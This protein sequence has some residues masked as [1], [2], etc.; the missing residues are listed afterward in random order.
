MNIGAEAVAE[1][2]NGYAARMY[3]KTA[4]L[5]KVPLAELIVRILKP[6]RHI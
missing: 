6:E 5:D 1:L 3:M 2:V 4:A